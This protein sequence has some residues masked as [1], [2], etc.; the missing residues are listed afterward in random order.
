VNVIHFLLY[1]LW[2][3]TIYLRIRKRQNLKK[4]KNKRSAKFKGNFKILG[5][6]ILQKPYLVFLRELGLS[7][8]KELQ[9][10]YCNFFD[11]QDL[12]SL[13]SFSFFFFYFYFY[14]PMT[15]LEVGS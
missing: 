10:K 12:T 4:S 3:G 5:R 13:L 8:V 15:L 14:L 7:A 1:T 2:G 9:H 6:L 11:V